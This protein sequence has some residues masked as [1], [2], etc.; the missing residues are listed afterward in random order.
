MICP[1]DYKKEDRVFLLFCCS[2][3][4]RTAVDGKE[5]GE[6]RRE[7]RRNAAKGHRPVYNLGDCLGLGLGLLVARS[8]RWATQCPKR[9]YAQQNLPEAKL[10]SSD[11]CRGRQRWGS[12]GGHA[13]SKGVRVFLGR[14]NKEPDLN[15][16]YLVNTMVNL[17]IYHQQKSTV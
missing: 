14:P 6:R 7:K 16:I 13:P 17:R 10:T 12:V 15:R 2:S 11:C 5:H 1:L 9:K 8:T 4:D 3:T